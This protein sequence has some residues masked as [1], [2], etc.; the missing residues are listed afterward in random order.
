MLFRSEGEIKLVEKVRNSNKAYLRLIEILQEET[1]KNGSKIVTITHV[2]NVE[3]AS[4]IKEAVLKFDQI[5]E[6]IMVKCAG[7]SSM[8]ADK[9]GI[10][11]AY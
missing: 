6:V 2:G 1:A 10:I 3:R 8:Y 11:V 5:E 7:L 4:Q 9:K